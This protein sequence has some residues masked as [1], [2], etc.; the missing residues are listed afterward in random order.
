MEGDAVA[1]RLL[2]L[3]VA[4][5]VSAAY[6][7]RVVKASDPTE[8]ASPTPSPSTGIDKAAGPSSSPLEAG[9]MPVMDYG[10]SGYRYK[11][12]SQGALSGFE[13]PGY[14]DVAGG[15]GTGSAAFADDT[16]SGPYA[17][18]WTGNTDILLRREVNMP[19]GASGV[20]VSVAI[21]NDIQVFWNGND[22]SGGLIQSEGCATYDEYTFTVP[23]YLLQAGD[24]LLAAR[25]RERGQSQRIDLKV[26]AATIERP[27]SCS[28]EEITTVISPANPNDRVTVRY[29]PRFLV[30]MS[31]PDPLG[32]ADDI[33]HYVQSRAEAA[34]TRYSDLGLPIP[35]NLTVEISCQLEWLQAPL[36]ANQVLN[37]QPPGFTGGARHV[38]LLASFLE[39]EFVDAVRNGFDPGPWSAENARW[40][41]TIDHEVF[42]SVQWEV[43]NLAIRYAGGDHT[44]TESPAV[45]ATDLFASADDLDASQYLDQVGQFARN[46][47]R[48]LDVTHLDPANQAEYQAAGALQY[49][50]ERFGPQTETN[51]ENR[52]ARFLNALI[53]ANFQA[54]VWGVA[55]DGEVA[56]FGEALGYDYSSSQYDDSDYGALDQAYGRALDALRDYYAAHLALGAQNI[57]DPEAS[58]GRYAI[59]DAITG[60][61]LPPGITPA[62]GVGDYPRLATVAELDLRAGPDTATRSLSSTQGEA[63]LIPVPSATTDVELTISVAPVGDP[64]A[65]SAPRLGFVRFGADGSVAMDPVQMPIGPEPGQSMSYSLGMNGYPTLGLVVVAG[66]RPLTYTVEA[67]AIIGTAAVAVDAPTTTDPVRVHDAREPLVLQATPTINGFTPWH[68]D[69]SSFRVRIGAVYAQVAAAYQWGDGYRIEANIPDT[70][71]A[72]TYDLTV[73]YAGVSSPPVPGGLVIDN[74]LPPPQVPVFSRSFDAVAQGATLEQ[75]VMVSAA[76]Q[77]IFDLSWSGSDFDLTLTAPGGR[78][79]TEAST[80]PDVTV[81]QSPNTVRITIASPAAGAWGVA[82][83]GTDVPVPEPVS[84]AVAEA[85]TPIHA[86]VAV[87]STVAA[88]DALD[89]RVS[90]ADQ[91]L[92]VSGATVVAE[93]TDPSGAI[94]SYPLFDDGAHRDSGAGDGLYGNAVW[95]TSQTGSYQ[96]RATVAGT[97]AN[98]DLFAREVGGS[99]AAGPMVDGD[100]DGVGDLAEQT[101]GSNPADPNDAL[102]DQDGDGVGLRDELTAGMDPLSADT[103][104]GGEPDGSEL[105]AGRDPRLSA[106][107]QATAAPVVHAVPADGR[108][109][110]LDMSTSTQAGTVHIWRLS[111]AQT[112]DLGS[113]PGGGAVMADGPLPAG[114]Y[115]YRAT[116]TAGGAE[117]TAALIGPLEV[118]DDVTPPEFRLV[119][120][121]SGWETTSATIGVAFDALTET[122]TQMRLAASA[123]ALESAAWTAFSPSA[124]VAVTTSEGRKSVFVQVR[125]AAGNP[126]SVHEGFVYLVDRTPPTSAAGPLDPSYSTPTVD[127]PF[128]ANDDLSGVG[129]VELWSRYRPIGGSWGAWTLGPSSATS[130]ITYTFGSTAGGSY[131]F[132]TIAVDAAGNREAA[133]ASADAATQGPDVSPIRAWGRNADGSLGAQTTETCSG[134]VSC[135]TVPLQVHGLT[136]VVAVEGGIQHTIALRA[137]GTVWTWGDNGLGQLGIGQGPD[138]PTPVQVTSLSN[139]VAVAAGSRCSY[140]VKSDGTVWGWGRPWCQIGNT[141]DGYTPAQV[142]GVSNITAVAAGLDFALARKADG[143]L[144][145]WGFNDYGQLGDNTTQIRVSAPVQTLISN[146]AS[147]AAGEAHSL[148]VK[149]DGTVW[150]WGRNDTGQL[151]IGSTRDQKRPQQVK[152]LSGAAFVAAGTQHSLALRQDG[153]VRAWGSNYLGQVGDGTTTTRLSPVVVPGLSGVARVSAGSNHSVALKTDGSVWGWGWGIYGQ[154]D[155][156]STSDRH[157]PTQM[158]ASSG[159]FI[160]IGAG[161]EYTFAVLSSP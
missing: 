121:D 108:I 129:N 161:D 15:F 103:D 70:L 33:A 91:E 48:I 79:I 46:N 27:A 17:T 40:K 13:A 116:A 92:G 19:A 14:D 154:L 118:A 39:G 102:I 139:V 84:L 24:N 149:T 124:S 25:G 125:D 3:V 137:D 110:N 49:W 134:S 135:S 99:F 77:A 66:N 54:G 130:P 68:L 28:N 150:S 74:A 21:D 73:E 32:A 60:F 105:A 142:A 153:S 145:A 12:V 132:Y 128:T 75:S 67:S 4:V 41:Q 96:V 119:V 89:V 112:T 44:Y 37:P 85:G 87:P 83:T 9:R 22:I 143:T 101:F 78:I 156:A 115:T 20:R 158:A 72:G 36:F 151:G 160:A 6:G 138:S 30:D 90:V 155:A 98:G 159:A 71:G 11:V 152:G 106:D 26:T 113:F 86:A 2:V 5:A 69:R 47:A 127:V 136:N 63:F 76:D 52:V 94:L 93:I 56:A 117:S 53:R 42:H 31:L 61:G 35:P 59:L 1:R 80:D 123:D 126:S 95:A 109:V 23:D 140:A 114:E 122:P 51:L 64:S 146:V 141:N 147:I 157:V 111:G 10:A 58:S 88:G 107:D 50:A 82:L 100:G 65:K 8:T 45:L 7:S 133:P 131:E 97:D 43:D 16:C 38:Q 144:W 34:L 120:N 55:T 104:G 29:D 18:S 148:A 81:E 62:Q 57:L